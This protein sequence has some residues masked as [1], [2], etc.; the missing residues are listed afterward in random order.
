M[1][2]FSVATRHMSWLQVRQ[3][4]LAGNIA[5]SDTPGYRARDIEAFRLT[6][7]TFQSA[8]Q[9]THAV[10]FGSTSMSVTTP[11]PQ[12]VF[13]DNDDVSHSG[14]TVSLEREMRKIGEAG[15]AFNFDTAVTKLFHRMSLLSVKA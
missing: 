11:Q 8:L 13:P 3:Q 6:P 7:P 15:S 9:A 5:N 14:N 2:V 10:H 4:V 12:I 1:D